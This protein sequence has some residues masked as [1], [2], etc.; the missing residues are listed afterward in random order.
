VEGFVYAISYISFDAQ[1]MYPDLVVK[2][3]S[4]MADED[5]VG[6]YDYLDDIAED[7]WTNLDVIKAWLRD[8]GC[9]HHRFPDT[10]WNS[11][12]FG[13]LV[14]EYCGKEFG[15][16]VAETLLSDKEFMMEAVH[17]NFS[18]LVCARDG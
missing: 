13:L 9:T 12:E 1:L 14:A 7:L 2:A 6:I 3:I 8:V 11:K 5:D 15:D 18:T 17:I 4:H 16:K 10:T